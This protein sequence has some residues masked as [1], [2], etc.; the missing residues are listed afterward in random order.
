[1]QDEKKRKKRD[2]RAYQRQQDDRKALRLQE[3]TL[4]KQ[5]IDLEQNE[6]AEAERARLLE[7]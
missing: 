2:P 7:A 4:D 6:I 5:D 1:M 3:C